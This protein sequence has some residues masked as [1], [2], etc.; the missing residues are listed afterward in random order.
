[1]L[2]PL[3][4]N[5]LPVLLTIL[6]LLLELS[7]AWRLQVNYADGVQIK[8]HGHHNSHC[9][10]FKKTDAPITSA[11]FE[12]S[13]TADTFVLYHDTKCR[14]EGYKGRKGNNAIPVTQYLS[15]KVY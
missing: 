9:R 5:C 12:P 6:F 4:T 15:Y 7:S 14:E 8:R 3:P 10:K 1:M 2:Q 11:Y 13:L